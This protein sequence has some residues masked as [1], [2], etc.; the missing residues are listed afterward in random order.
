MTGLSS[1]S[2]NQILVLEKSVRLSKLNTQTF[3]KKGYFELPIKRYNYNTNVKYKK[4]HAKYLIPPFGYNLL[5]I[6]ENYDRLKKDTYEIFREYGLNIAFDK[7][8]QSIKIILIQNFHVVFFRYGKQ[9]IETTLPTFDD[10]SLT[11][12]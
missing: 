2:Q 12:A 3:R 9:V 8:S 7:A 5:S 10:I 4:S 11:T 6:I 1:E